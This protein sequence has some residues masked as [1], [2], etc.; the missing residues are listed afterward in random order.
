MLK[1]TLKN[2]DPQSLGQRFVWIAKLKK[3]IN[4]FKNDYK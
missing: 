1:E 4:V 3:N 2:K